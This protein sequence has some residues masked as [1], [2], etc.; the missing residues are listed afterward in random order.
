MTCIHIWSLGEGSRDVPG[1][2]KKCGEERVFNGSRDLDD[3]WEFGFSAKAR[4]PSPARKEASRKRGRDALKAKAA[5][6]EMG[7]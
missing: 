5:A 1:R 7:D 2:C 4:P 3:Y 6:M